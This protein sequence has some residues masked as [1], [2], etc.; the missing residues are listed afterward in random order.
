MS[1]TGLGTGNTRKKQ[2]AVEE[3]AGTKNSIKLWYVYCILLWGDSK[4]TI[5]ST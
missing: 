5:H 2:P 4:E 1:D 3:I